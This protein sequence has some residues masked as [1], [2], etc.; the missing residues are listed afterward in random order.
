MSHQNGFPY[1]SA[2]PGYAQQPSQPHPQPRPQ[3]QPQA[4]EA[5]DPGTMLNVYPFMTY[6]P[7]ARVAQHLSSHSS[8]PQPSPTAHQ[9]YPHY[10]QSFGRIEQ[11]LTPGDWEMRQAADMRVRDVL[12]AQRQHGGSYGYSNAPLPSMRQFNYSQVPPT[13]VPDANPYG[14]YPQPHS[15]SYP[16]VPAYMPPPTPV[17]STGSRH[18]H[19]ATPDSMTGDSPASVPSGKGYFEGFVNNTLARHVSQ[20]RPAPAQS[21]NGTPS[22]LPRHVISQEQLRG[23][24][25]YRSSPEIRPA[26]YSQPQNGQT[27]PQYP[28]QMSYS[29]PQPLHRAPGRV[30]FPSQ[31]IFQQGVDKSATLPLARGKSPAK[32]PSISSMAMRSPHPSSSVTSTPTHERVMSSPYPSSSP[33]PLGMPT[34]SPSKKPRKNRTFSPSLARSGNL[35]NDNAMGIDSLSMREKPA[36]VASS[37][38]G[39]EQKQKIMLRLPMHLATPQRSPAP[40]EGQ[41][42]DAEG[43]EEEDGVDW[44]DDGV[45]DAEG[46]WQMEEGNSSGTVYG[47]AAGAQIQMSGKTGERDTR[48]SWQKLQTLLEDISEENDSFT[49]NPTLEDLQSSNIK[50]FGH[51]SR[52]GSQALLSQKT[53]SK[54]IRYVLRVRS[55]KKR[56]GQEA[57]GPE[58]VWDI[59]LV[60]TLLRLLERSIRDVED[61]VV[62]PDD[63]KAAVAIEEKAAKKKGKGKAGSASPVKPE[64]AEVKA[65]IPLADIQACEDKL[66]R[67]KRSVAAAECSLILLD[68]EGISKQLY[69]EELLSTCVKTVKDQLE[70]VVLPVIQ[71]LAGDKIGSSYLARLVEQEHN[72]VALKFKLP[73][74]LSSHF[75][76]HTLSAIAQS[77]CI[78]LPRLTS[79][80]SRDDFNFSEGLLIQTVYLAK[81]PLFVVDPVV[82]KKKGDKDGMAVV[83]SM[84]MEGLSLLRGVFARYEEQRQWIIEEVLS[85]LVGQAGQSHDQALFQLSNGKSIHAVSA[86]LLQLIQA[87]AYGAVAQVK[88]VYTASTEME[89]FDRQETEKVDTVAEESRICGET[90][91]SALKSATMVAGYIL[92]KATTTRATKTSLDTDYKVI[93]SLFINDLLAVL[94]RPEWPAASLYL[95]VFSKIMINALDEKKTGTEA[96]AAKGVALDYLADIV[97]RLKNLSIEMLGEIK[98]ATIDEVISEASVTGLTRLIKAQGSI[99]AFLTSA[100]RDDGSFACS[101][102]MASIMWAQELQ[103]GVKK[104]ASVLEKLAVEK[105]DETKELGDNLRTIGSMLSDTLR[106]VW[107]SDDNLFEVN[108]PK[109]GEQA[110]QASIAVSRGRS[111]QGAIDPIIHTLLS[112]M[113]NTIIGLRTK[114]LRGISSIVVVDPDVLRLPQIRH[115]LEERLSDASPGVRDAAV[116]LVG[117]YLVQKPELVPQYYQQIASRVMDTGLSVRKRVIKILK[118]IFATME[119][120]KMQVDICCRMIALV[121]DKDPG[122]KSLS[123]KTLVDMLFSGEGGDAARM[124]VDILSNYRGSYEVLEKALDEVSKECESVGQKGRFG[125]TIDDLINRLIDATEENDFD[126]LSHIRAI[127]LLAESDPSQ[128]DM[129]K[130]NVLLGYLR[131][132]SNADDQ[133]TNEL[134]LKVFQRSIPAM[135]RTASTFANSLTKTLMPMI[136]KPAGGFTA[137]REIIGCFCAVTKHLTK[138]W[139]KAINVLRACEAKIRSVRPGVKNGSVTT[140][141]PAIAMMLYITALLVEGCNLDEIAKQDDA[142]DAQVRRISPQPLAVYFFELYLDFASMSTPHSAPTICLGALFRAYPSLLQLPETTEW[143]EKTFESND[144]DGQCRL[145]GVLHQFLS[146]EVKKR[147]SAGVANKDVNLLIGNSKELQDSDYSTVIVQNNIEQIFK[148]A[149]SQH[150]PTQNAAL[151]VITFV[152]NQ[153]LYSPVHTVPILVTLETAEDPIIAERALA[154][155][156]TLHDKHAN[157]IHVL[158]MDSARASYQYQRGITAEPSGHRNGIALL[159]S[160]YEMLSEKR[161]WRHDFLKALCRAFDSDLDAEVDIGFVLYIAEN[162]ATMDYKLQEEPM[163]VVQALS[164]IVSTCSHLATLIEEAHINAPPEE[165][166]DGQAINLGK[167]SGETIKAGR[168]ADASIIVGLA[169]MLKNHLVSLYHLQEDKCAAHVPGKKSAT[170]DKPC[171]RRGMQV[172]DLDRMSMVRGIATVGDFKQQQ[173]AFLELLKEDGTLSENGD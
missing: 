145:L 134:L 26:P 70:Q 150:V 44:G 101:L 12:E 151:D 47:G 62:F 83:K 59:T 29:Q 100:A 125:T 40:E 141:N 33:D 34:P 31:P 118:G 15:T 113:S 67:V 172:L 137:L 144:M 71:G 140:L 27:P 107:L 153:G 99:R 64:D 39:E 49:A 167:L 117:K 58:R 3:P 106:G 53:M 89:V 54:V 16:F 18:T 81:G 1:F 19:P 91:E 92:S 133:A 173:T 139:P 171:Q 11:P 10:T 51:V 77:I 157:L 17:S 43:D 57:N 147:A 104:T 146:S 164:R 93:L 6:A 56:P 135:P 128:I 115:A 52:D 116:E 169:L 75:H 87:S 66:M 61:I 42:E 60:S 55:G 112:T 163:T 2:G 79:L 4:A 38:S 23:Y 36:S 13:P 82:G 132:P 90:I 152:V 122:I 170:G 130:A 165:S 7:T 73:S 30:P 143:M 80:I 45:R 109:Q 160:W 98:V 85:S 142:I 69:S 41:D 68:S 148:C 156:S 120:R 126:S 8:L 103:A 74:P 28:S 9:V 159:S 5:E 111:L 21:Q 121:D 155:H 162:L 161:T 37:A 48:N 105:D 72:A 129:Q 124:F 102:D 22:N 158:F 95:S 127:W 46:D 35:A 136:S 123:T 84:R 20:E 97:A 50:F 88:K 131:P 32:R 65:E 114:A 94:Y 63:R 154:L 14:G 96:T 166:I 149:R 108:D 168:L 78:T 24:D 119:N 25:Q 76:H 138:D 110:V 86:L